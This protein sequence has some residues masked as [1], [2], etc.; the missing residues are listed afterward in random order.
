ML[1]LPIRRWTGLS[2]RVSTCFSAAPASA[3]V[4]QPPRQGT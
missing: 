3:G 4:V 2:L 1:T